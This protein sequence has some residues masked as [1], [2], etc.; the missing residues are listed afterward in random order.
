MTTIDIKTITAEIALTLPVSDL[1]PAYRALRA[2]LETEFDALGYESRCLARES[3]HGSPGIGGA[4]L[5]H[6]NDQRALLA[7]RRE[8]YERLVD[9]K[10]LL[11]ILTGRYD[12]R[13]PGTD[14]TAPAV[15]RRAEI[16]AERRTADRGVT[17]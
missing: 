7:N 5:A 12:D 2:W 9:V 13:L 14:A 15:R 3:A 17:P 8:R 4:R 1:E 6:A 16:V 10:H 11:A